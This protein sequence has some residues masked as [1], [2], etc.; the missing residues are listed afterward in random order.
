MKTACSVVWALPSAIYYLSSVKSFE[1]RETHS[2]V[3]SSWQML[4]KPHHFL[5]KSKHRGRDLQSSLGTVS[6]P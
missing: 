3:T 1:Q 5:R 2:V 4:D 6:H